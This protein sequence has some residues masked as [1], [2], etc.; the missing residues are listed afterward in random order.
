[1]LR[2]CYLPTNFR[3]SKQHRSISIL[4]CNVP[5]TFHPHQLHFDIQTALIL[6]NRNTTYEIADIESITSILPERLLLGPIR[7]I[8]WRRLGKWLMTSLDRGW[9]DK[10]IQE[11]RSLTPIRCSHSDWQN[12]SPIYA[13]AF[14]T[15]GFDSEFILSE[16]LTGAKECLTTLY[17]KYSQYP[18]TITH[19]IDPIDPIIH[20]FSHCDTDHFHT[21]ARNWQ[22]H[23]VA[24]CNVPGFGIFP[25]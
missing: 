1:M 11:C 14:S 10:C 19:R 6:C 23:L 17:Q 4:N 18:Q 2:Y 8:D 13:F 12:T 25:N 15:P 16:I 3:I 20:T 7:T 9:A 22:F 24:P 5:D 21:Y